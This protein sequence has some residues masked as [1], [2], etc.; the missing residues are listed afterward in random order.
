MPRGKRKITKKEL[1]KKPD[2]FITFSNRSYNWIRIHL[3]SVLWVVSGIILLAALYL[4][5]GT[6]QN[7]QERLAH[8]AYFSAYPVTDPGQKIKKLED[9]VADYPRTKG[10]ASARVTLGHLYYQKGESA[11]AI[12][13]YQ[14]ALDRSGFPANIRI[15]IQESLA[16]AYEQKGDLPQAAKFL[17]EITLTESTLLKEDA[18]LA[19]ARVYQ[20]MGK[21][22]EA[23]ATYEKFLKS[24][25]KSPYA[26]VV[27]D[28]LNRP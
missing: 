17:S 1:L 24:Y 15:M 16:Y 27:K 9:L 10:A 23:K 19:L 6:Y 18:F 25:P 26:Q 8:E 22:G 7:Y 11:K 21:T 2:E 4:A 28:R 12:A 3:R 14:G 5:Y 13:A 20:K